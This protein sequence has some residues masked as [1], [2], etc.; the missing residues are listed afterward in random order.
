MVVEIKR[1]RE[2]R[3]EVVDEVAEKI[4]RLK[5]DKS[6]SVRTALVYDGHLPASVPA[7]RY[8]DFIVPAEVLITQRGKRTL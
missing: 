7:D 1:Q 8:F 5:H 4:R 3:H 2:I 6:L